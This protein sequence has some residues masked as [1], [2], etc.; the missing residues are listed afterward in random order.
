MR[1]VHPTF[2]IHLVAAAANAV[3][4]RNGAPGAHVFRCK[5]DTVMRQIQQTKTR[6]VVHGQIVRDGEILAVSQSFCQ[7]SVDDALI[8]VGLLVPSRR[9]KHRVDEGAAI[10]DVR[11]NHIHP[12][13]LNSPKSNHVVTSDTTHTPISQLSGHR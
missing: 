7:R 9:I 13:L 10:A 12:M 1:K 3:P 5:P 11:I 2:E 4:Q 6:T 8:F